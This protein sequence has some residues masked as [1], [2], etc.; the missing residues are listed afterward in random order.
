MKLIILLFVCASVLG[1]ECP[2][3]RTRIGSIRKRRH[4]TFPDGSTLVL[5]VSTAKT[6]L[7]HIPSGWNLVMELDL[8]FNLP[9]PNFTVAHARRKLHHR[10]KRQ[11]WEQLQK[12]IDYYNLNG[13][14]CVLRSI[15]EAK[16]YLAPPGRSL[17]HDILR[18]IFTAPTHEGDFREEIKDVYEDILDPSYCKQMNDCPFSLLSFILFIN[19]QRN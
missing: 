14:A 2:N 19:K 10:Q 18:S 13:R 1:S 8:I 7:T 6:F 11:I 5:T 4:L 9:G 16:S 15:C 12:S 17:V 3:V